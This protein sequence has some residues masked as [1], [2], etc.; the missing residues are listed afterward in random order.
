M[1]SPLEPVESSVRNATRAADKKRKDLHGCYEVVGSVS[2]VES[3][4]IAPYVSVRFWPKVA[5]HEHPLLT[6]PSQPSEG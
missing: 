4:L 2:M 3:G 5:I 6:N 1:R